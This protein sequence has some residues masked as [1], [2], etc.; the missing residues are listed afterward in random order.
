MRRVVAKISRDL[1]LGNGGVSIVSTG[2]R[3][4]PR[5]FTPCEIRHRYASPRKVYFGIGF[6]A[7]SFHS[8]ETKDATT[9]LSEIHLGNCS[10]VSHCRG[11]GSWS[12]IC[13]AGRERSGDC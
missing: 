12:V 6:S 11:P 3:T 2:H 5:K 4:H 9:S 13:G 7:P 10:L 8:E 1:R